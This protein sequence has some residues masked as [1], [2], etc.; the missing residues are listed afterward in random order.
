MNIYLIFK[1]L[2]IIGFVSWFAALFYIPRLFIYHVETSTQDEPQKTAF[3][4][5]FVLMEKRLYGII[6]TPAMLITWICGITMLV[7]AQLAP[8][9]PDWITQGWM[10]LKLLL[11]ILLTGYHHLCKSILKKLES[12]TLDWTSDKLRFFNE[13][14]TILLIAIVGIAVFKDFTNFALLFVVLF[15]IGIVL[16]IATKAYK[17]YRMRTGK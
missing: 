1:I 9:I 15:A 8:E 6:M 4:N 3:H 2:H 17:K 5:Q 10:H 16:Y 14:P 11:L 7:Y 13:I 12:K